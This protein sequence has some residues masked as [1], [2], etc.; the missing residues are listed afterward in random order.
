MARPAP[1]A[2]TATASGRREKRGFRAARLPIHSRRPHGAV[3]S[4]ADGPDSASPKPQRQPLT[5]RPVPDSPAP[6]IAERPASVPAPAARD[7]A[8]HV[9]AFL[10]ERQA[11]D[12]QVLDVSRPLAIVDYFV[13]AT[14][15]NTRQAQALA[16]E[17]DFDV[18]RARGRRKRNQGGLET[19]DSNWVLLDFD[20]VVVHLFLPEARAYYGLESLWADSPRMVVPAVPAERVEEPRQVRQA[21]KRM[22]LFPP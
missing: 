17:L 5:N 12:V 13:I 22:Q 2:R 3:G 21:Q 4:T 9:A 8:R 15:R 19:E 10:G 18:K 6:K 20:D 11:E 14:V 7:L 1:P 16:R